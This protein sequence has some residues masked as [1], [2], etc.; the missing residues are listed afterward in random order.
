MRAQSSYTLL[1]DDELAFLGEFRDPWSSSGRLV[2][3]LRRAVHPLPSGDCFPHLGTSAAHPGR[4]RI[5]IVLTMAWRNAM[6]RATYKW[7]IA[8]AWSSRLEIF[9]LHLSKGFKLVED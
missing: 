2:A 6:L 1:F 4:V 9:N 8:C 7:Q 3:P 5:G